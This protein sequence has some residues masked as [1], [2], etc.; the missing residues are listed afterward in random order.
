MPVK[1]T[2]KDAVEILKAR[3]I[4]D[5]A[6]KQSVEHERE[7]AAKDAEIERLTDMNHALEDC[8]N[9]SSRAVYTAE[10]YDAIR[11]DLAAARGK[12]EKAEMLMKRR[13]EENGPFDYMG[14]LLKQILT[15]EGV[16]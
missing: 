1:T 16:K 4:T 14:L 15:E 6:R 13:F 9:G 2:T 10:M 11:A 8:L 12:V 3:Y 5:D 7:I